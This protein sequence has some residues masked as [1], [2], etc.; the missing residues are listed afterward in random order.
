MLGFRE[1]GGVIFQD[2]EPR[3]REIIRE[4]KIFQKVG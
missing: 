1:H 4:E 3:K 2:R